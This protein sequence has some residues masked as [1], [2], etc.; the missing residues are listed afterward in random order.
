[1]NPAYCDYRKHQHKT[2][3]LDKW[4]LTQ[5]QNC[6]YYFESNIQSDQ[7]KQIVVEEVDFI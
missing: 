6:R 7:L 1:M 5:E 4:S 3:I 2:V